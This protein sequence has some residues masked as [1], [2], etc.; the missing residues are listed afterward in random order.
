MNPARLK[1]RMQHL[2]GTVFM[3]WLVIFFS[4]RIHEKHYN[5]NP[6]N[7]IN[8]QSNTRYSLSHGIVSFLGFKSLYGD[9]DRDPLCHVTDNDCL[10]LG[11][12]SL[13]TPI[14]RLYSMQD[15][16]FTSWEWMS[17]TT[18]AGSVK[19]ALRRVACLSLCSFLWYHVWTLHKKWV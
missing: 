6:Y 7:Q 4:L 5:C 9:M 8:D 1:P 18:W 14:D 11:D 17:N 12:S 16:Y 3:A 19:M 13:L 10:S 15:S 2:C